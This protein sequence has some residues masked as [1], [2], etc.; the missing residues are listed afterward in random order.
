M[1][2]YLH[3]NGSIFASIMQELYIFL[4]VLGHKNVLRVTAAFFRGGF[5]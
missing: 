5:H 3:Y 1:L 2:V 4:A